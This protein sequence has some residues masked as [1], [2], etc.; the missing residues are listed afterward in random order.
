M[1]WLV[2]FWASTIGKKVVMG[3]TGAGLM[4]F[5]FLHMAGNLQMFLGPDV[6]RRY[7]ELLRTSEEL[8]W[9]A[10]LGLLAMAVLHVVA[11]VQ[12]TRINNA[13]RPTGYAKQEPQVSTWAARTMRIGGVILVVFLV[14]HLG[15]L[16][17]GW[18]HPNLVHLQPYSNVILGFRSPWVVLFYVVAMAFLGLHLFHGAW[19]AWRTLGLKKRS[20]APLVRQLALG[21]AIIVWAGFTVIPV[22]V[23]LGILN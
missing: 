14:Y 10:R 12:L 4:A 23:F 22:A 3:V 9:V 17:I 16:T 19:A 2:K 21:F 18:F 13:A 5:A 7:A 8:L 1:S 15:H 11:A 20:A 6:M